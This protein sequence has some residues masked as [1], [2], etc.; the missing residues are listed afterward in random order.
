M[1]KR[2][3]LDLFK[4]YII[5]A[6]STPF[7]LFLKEIC[8]RLYSSGMQGGGV[9][10][11]YGGGG[12]KRK[13]LS[14]VNGGTMSKAHIFSSFKILNWVHEL[15]SI[16]GTSKD[17][18]I[19]TLLCEILGFKKFHPFFDL[20][21]NKLIPNLNFLTF[22]INCLCFDSFKKRINGFYKD[23]YIF[24]RFFGFCGKIFYDSRLWL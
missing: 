18:L 3:N 16:C 2:K 1:L 11:C 13:G 15:N 4:R 20:F 7:N 24:C 8:H 10:Q 14:R 21:L 6:F 19:I 17:Y 12:K 23:N 22:F 5:G 9:R